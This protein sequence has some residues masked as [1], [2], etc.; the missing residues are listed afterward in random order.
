[1]PYILIGLLQCTSILLAARAVFSVP[2]GGN[3]VAV[4]C[5]EYAYDLTRLEVLRARAARMASTV[6]FFAAVGGDA[7]RPR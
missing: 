5:H 1:M 4:Y 3:P 2:F 7:D 6:S